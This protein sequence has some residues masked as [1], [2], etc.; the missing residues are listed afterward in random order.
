MRVKKRKEKMFLA[1]R[2]MITARGHNL[3]TFAYALGITQQALSAKLSGRSD[4]TLKEIVKA[5]NILGTSDV[6]I[7]FEPKLHN[8]HFLNDKAVS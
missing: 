3:K 5:C 6:T 7:F 4:F 2:A 1:L 8:L